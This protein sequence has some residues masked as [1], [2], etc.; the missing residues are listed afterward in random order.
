MRYEK[1]KV[2]RCIFSSNF[3][4]D[5]TY[6]EWTTYTYDRVIRICNPVML[7]AL[8]TGNYSEA[9]VNMGY[10]GVTPY[11]H[12]VYGTVVNWEAMTS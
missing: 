8:V 12:P 10:P 2:Y 1:C 11:T 9:D 4:D 3:T 5:L 7:W 6:V